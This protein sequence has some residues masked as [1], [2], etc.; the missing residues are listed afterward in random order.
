MRWGHATG[1]RLA[2]LPGT[3]RF[4]GTFFAWVWRE[5]WVSDDMKMQVGEHCIAERVNFSPLQRDQ[6]PCSLCVRQC[7]LKSNC[8]RY[9]PCFPSLLA[10]SDSVEKMPVPL[11]TGCSWPALGWAGSCGQGEP[12]ALS[13]MNRVRPGVGI[14]SA[15]GRKGPRAVPRLSSPYV[16]HMIVLRVTW[17]GEFRF[18]WKLVCVSSPRLMECRCR[19]E[20]EGA[21]GGGRCDRL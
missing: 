20:H 5:T 19:A 1:M 3:P 18:E 16:L 21:C 14:S 7:F 15:P 13:H 12:A 11:L 6:Q 17:S 4:W 9:S 8:P 10:C 2:R